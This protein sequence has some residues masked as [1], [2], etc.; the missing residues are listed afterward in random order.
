MTFAANDAGVITGA[1]SAVVGAIAAT[2][3]VVALRRLD[4]KE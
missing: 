3:G 1:C 4:K 2:I